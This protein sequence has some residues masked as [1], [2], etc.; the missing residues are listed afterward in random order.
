[1]L[2]RVAGAP[3]LMEGQGLKPG[4]SYSLVVRST[5]VTVKSGVVSSGG[6]FSHSLNMPTG[7]A[8]GVHTISLSG[9]GAGGERLVLTQSFTVAANG[10]FSAMGSVT[11]HVTGGLAATGPNHALLLGGGSLAALLLVAGVSLLIARR[12][13]LV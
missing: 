11:G 12:Q 8:P 10:T 9:V 7:I 4:S 6:S 3:V 13:A 5:P 2:D 1:V